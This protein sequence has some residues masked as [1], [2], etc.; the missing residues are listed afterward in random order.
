MAPHSSTLAWKI[1]WT[2]EPGRLQSMGSLRVGHDWATSNN[3][4]P[5]DFFA[6]S[7]VILTGQTQRTAQHFRTH[8]RTAAR[9]LP[10]FT[11]QLVC[12]RRPLPTLPP[13]HMHL[14]RDALVPSRAEDGVQ[15]LDEGP[16]ET[17]GV[18]L[19][20]RHAGHTW[21]LTPRGDASGPRRGRGKGSRSAQHFK[22]EP[23]N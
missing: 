6:G 15:C 16:A 2:T 3:A 4:H 12:T 13:T 22:R 18:T 19:V 11:G 23:K 10:R 5:Q 1:P 8:Q 17:T 20:C 7:G 21:A 14:L 9:R